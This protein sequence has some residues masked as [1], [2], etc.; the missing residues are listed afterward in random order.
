MQ[1]FLRDRLGRW[2]EVQG[3]EAGEWQETWYSKQDR[4]VF[5]LLHSQLAKHLCRTCHMP[6]MD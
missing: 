5:Y 4:K 2:Q 6:D 1:L 3:W